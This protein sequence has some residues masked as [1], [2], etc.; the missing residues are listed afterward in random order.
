MSKYHDLEGLLLL[1]LGVS[2]AISIPLT[3]VWPEY[4]VFPQWVLTALLVMWI[5]GFT[6]WAV[7]GGI[8]PRVT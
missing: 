1:I 8:P 3:L 2:L 5:V 7:T 6:K 4:N